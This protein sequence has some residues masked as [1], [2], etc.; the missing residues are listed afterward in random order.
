MAYENTMTTIDIWVNKTDISQ[1]RIVQ[2]TMNKDRQEDGEAML[3]V[4]RFSFRRI[5]SVVH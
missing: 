1:A 4:N 3:Q 2:K 5:I